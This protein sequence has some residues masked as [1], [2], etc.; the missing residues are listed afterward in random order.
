MTVKLLPEDHLEFLSLTR[1]GTGSPESIH[2][3][4]PHSWKS[5]CGSYAINLEMTT[6]KTQNRL[7]TVENHKTGW[8]NL[9]AK[10]RL[11]FYF[12]DFFFN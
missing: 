11:N 4:M 1:G 5:R 8:K 2:V 3:K 12:L 10:K 6:A 9:T 7:Q